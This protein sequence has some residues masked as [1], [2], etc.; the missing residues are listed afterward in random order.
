MDKAYGGMSR[1]MRKVVEGSRLWDV[2]SPM[3]WMN[4]VQRNY[5]E[6]S[7]KYDI[8]VKKVDFFEKSGFNAW[9]EESRSEF[10]RRNVYPRR[11]RDVIKRPS[12]Y[13]KREWRK[14]RYDYEDYEARYNN[15]GFKYFFR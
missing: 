1:G 8:N 11:G 4:R 3:T 7:S 13:V 2:G 14:R 10:R 5:E 6:I 15:A 9:R 12:Y